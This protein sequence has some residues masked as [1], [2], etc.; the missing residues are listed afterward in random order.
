ML[1]QGTWVRG[2]RSGLQRGRS[3]KCTKAVVV[4][5]RM[6]MMVVVVPTR[7]AMMVLPEMIH[8]SLLS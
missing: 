2:P 7:T 6:A 1:G 3:E 8:R 5:T 4:L